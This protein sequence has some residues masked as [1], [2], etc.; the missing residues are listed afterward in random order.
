MSHKMHAVCS[1]LHVTLSVF[2]VS[3]ASSIDSIETINSEF[4][5]YSYDRPRF[6]FRN[7]ISP[8]EAPRGSLSQDELQLLIKK[9]VLDPEGITLI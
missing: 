2:D 1:G 4:E 6:E 8:V 5:I 7:H 9:L 3:A